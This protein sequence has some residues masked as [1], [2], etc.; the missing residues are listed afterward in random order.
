MSNIKV[1][2]SYYSEKIL[3]YDKVR[4]LRDELKAI[5]R[6]ADE[7]KA[8]WYVE[9]AGMFCDKL[10]TILGSLGILHLLGED[11]FSGSSGTAADQYW[12]YDDIEATMYS[13]KADRVKVKHKNE[14]IKIYI[15]GEV[16]WEGW[17]VVNMPTPIAYHIGSGWVQV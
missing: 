1:V 12:A 10:G 9:L 16:A 4:G 8:P 13:T 14:Y 5:Y 6:G 17:T 11:Y 7:L 15:E 2:D 3:S